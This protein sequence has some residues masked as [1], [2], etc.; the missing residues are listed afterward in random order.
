[1][2]E[3]SP[4][5]I[6]I[7]FSFTVSQ[8]NCSS[9]K[10]QDNPLEQTGISGTVG[11]AAACWECIYTPSRM[12]T[13]FTLFTHQ[14]CLH[15]RPDRPQQ[16]LQLWFLTMLKAHDDF[17]LMTCFIWFL[18]W[19]WVHCLLPEQLRAIRATMKSS[20]MWFN[21][22]IFVHL[23]V[24]SFDLYLPTFCYSPILLFYFLFFLTLPSAYPP[25][26]SLLP[27]SCLCS[28]RSF[29]ACAAYSW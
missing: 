2:S 11:A 15:H 9:D 24:W 26:S 10:V 3:S 4:A 22:I 13:L 17:N 12:L 5:L 25:L 6:S 7:P 23:I 29:T 27:C 19:K 28:S 18:P 21:L 14:Q 8:F 20:G 1:M 16:C